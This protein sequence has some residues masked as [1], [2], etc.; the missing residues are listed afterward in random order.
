[1]KIWKREHIEE[2]RATLTEE[3]FATQPISAKDL[4]IQN[5]WSHPL[6]GISVYQWTII[7]IVSTGILIIGLWCYCRTPK[8]SQAPTQE[9]KSNNFELKAYFGPQTPTHM[10]PEAQHPSP[11]APPKP[12]TNDQGTSPLANNKTKWEKLADKQIRENPFQLN[13]SDNCAQNRTSQR[14]NRKTMG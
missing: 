1:M 9:G 13:S 7:V 3:D 10:H 4:T 5:I 6:G 11:V 14:E 12:G 8:Y 2:E